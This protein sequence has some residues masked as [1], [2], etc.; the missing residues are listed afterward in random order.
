VTLTHTG[1]FQAD[2]RVDVYQGRKS[3]LKQSLVYHSSCSQNLFN[4]D[5]FGAVTLMGFKSYYQNSVCTPTN[6]LTPDCDPETDPECPQP[7]CDRE[8]CEVRPD[9]FFFKLTGGS[10]SESV[11]DQASKFYCNEMGTYDDTMGKYLEF[12]DTSGYEVYYS[13]FTAPNQ[14]VTLVPASGRFPAD[15]KIRVYTAANKLYKLQDIQY[16]SSC[17]KNL[18]NGDSFGAVTLVGFK[19]Y[20]QDVKCF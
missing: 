10:C 15:M 7:P 11:N 12:T 2:M 3:W 9:Q 4:G 18:Y 20:Y 16:H 6:C 5:I 8:I 17:S 13:G 14:V 1:K 19:S